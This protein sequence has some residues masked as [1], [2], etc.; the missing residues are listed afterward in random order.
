MLAAISEEAVLNAIVQIIAAAVGALILPG[1]QWLL[2]RSRSG[3]NA[4]NP[5]GPRVPRW[6]II[7]SSIVLGL[8]SLWLAVRLVGFGTW[9]VTYTEVTSSGSPHLMRPEPW[10]QFPQRKSDNNSSAD[11]DF[12][13]PDGQILD[14]FDQKFGAEVDNDSNRAKQNGHVFLS[15]H[16]LSKIDDRHFHFSGVN[17]GGSFK[18]L[19]DIFTTDVVRVPITKEEHHWVKFMLI[20]VDVPR[21]ATDAFVTGKL[22][23]KSFRFSVPVPESDA[24]DLRFVLTNREEPVPEAPDYN[25]YWYRLVSD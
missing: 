7:S 2:R 25:R 12:F 3:Q 5:N 6:L 13:V 11:G 21:N 24:R 14:H 17:N 1:I 19:L 15:Q 10:F 8:G 20:T 18:V 9:Q 16:D 23:G 22:L 4:A